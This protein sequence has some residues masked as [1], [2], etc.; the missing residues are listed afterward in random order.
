MLFLGRS[1][2]WQATRPPSAPDRSGRELKTG[3]RSQPAERLRIGKSALHQRRVGAKRP[4]LK[5]WAPV[6]YRRLY[7]ILLGQAKAEAGVITRITKN[8][9]EWLVQG[10]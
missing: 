5:V 6:R 7:H 9:D 4:N 1:P 2:A 3:L 8:S 10:L